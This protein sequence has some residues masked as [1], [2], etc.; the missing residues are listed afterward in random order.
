MIDN[1][2][3]RA[4]LEERGYIFRWSKSYGWKIY[5]IVKYNV[6]WQTVVD[7][8]G[9][10]SYDLVEH[11]YEDVALNIY[12]KALEHFLHEE[13]GR[14]WHGVWKMLSD[15]GAS[16]PELISFLSLYEVAA[17]HEAI[18]YLEALSE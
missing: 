6:T 9:E 3:I 15:I 1:A 2:E 7:A 14:H 17:I 11:S 13:L 12:K 5:K 10:R 8:Y 4:F 18:R 16:A